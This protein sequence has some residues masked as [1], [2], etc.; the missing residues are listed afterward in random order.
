MEGEVIDSRLVSYS[1]RT[2]LLSEN[3]WFRV[4]AI[5]DKLSKE[6]RQVDRRRLAR[7]ISITLTNLMANG[8]VERINKGSVYLYRWK[9][10]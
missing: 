2:I 3:K 6:F 7:I 9:G 5:T 1:V 4:R 8:H 10:F